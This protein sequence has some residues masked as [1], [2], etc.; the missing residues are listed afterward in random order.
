MSHTLTKPTDLEVEKAR[1]QYEIYLQAM[2]KAP[3]VKL[4]ETLKKVHYHVSKGRRV[5]NL[6]EVLK[7]GG[8]DTE[9]GYPRLA[10]C[11]ADATEV[12]FK[13]TH[14]WRGDPDMRFQDSNVSSWTERTVRDISLPLD[15]FQA[16]VD[17]VEKSEDNIY[18][19]TKVPIIPIYARP[20]G[21]KGLGQYYVLWEVEGWK[22]ATMKR[23]P[24]PRDPYL[25]RRI[26]ENMFVILT[27]WDLT[28]LERSVMEGILE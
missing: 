5:F 23:P 1:Q 16:L 17:K 6:Y 24:V 26:S 25:C 3:G 22:T 13:I 9:H 2:K 7:R 8:C 28:E 15:V 27:S 18:L 11:R 12:R 10:I 14:N 19:Y 4:Y 20:K 21:V